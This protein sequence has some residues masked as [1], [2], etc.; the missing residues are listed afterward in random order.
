MNGSFPRPVRLGLIHALAHSAGPAREALRALWPGCEVVER[1]DASLSARRAA[2]PALPVEAFTDRFL[3]LASETLAQGAAGLLFTC[4]AFGP[5]IQAVA[6]QHPDRPV[7][8]PTEAMVEEASALGVPIGLV[9][10]F[11]PTLASLAPE[12]PSHVRLEPSLA[13]GALA[14]LDRGDVADHD[15]AIAEAAARLVAQGCGV[16]A[17][18]QISMARAAPVVAARCGV[19]VL[20]TTGSAIRRLRARLERRGGEVLG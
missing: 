11:A 18:A 15:E 6:R 1:L 9:A 12:F 16:I 8:G 19:P 17:L 13:E 20:T 10:T 14:A 4:S 7:L 2:E 5:C 3:A